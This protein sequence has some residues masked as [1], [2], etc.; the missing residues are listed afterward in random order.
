MNNLILPIF[1]SVNQDLHDVIYKLRQYS[2]FG[3]Y[4]TLKV[5]DIDSEHYYIS[6]ES[7]LLLRTCTIYKTYEMLK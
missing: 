4:F 1:Q 6:T 2:R 7:I 3:L 5:Y